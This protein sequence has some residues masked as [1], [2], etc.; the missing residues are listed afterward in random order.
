MSVGVLSIREKAAAVFFRFKILH[1]RQRFHADQIP[2]EKRP[3]KSHHI[4][5][6]GVDIACA[7]CAFLELMIADRAVGNARFISD[8]HRTGVLH[9]E[10]LEDLF[11]DCIFKR[12]ACD[13]FDDQSQKMIVRI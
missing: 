12:F 11:F 13:L 9:P 7:S 5:H 1:A 6:A 8:C 2:A 3:V 10:R 4:R